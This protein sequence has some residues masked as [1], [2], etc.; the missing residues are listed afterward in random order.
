MP[1]LK[2]QLSKS[3]NSDTVKICSLCTSEE[4]VFTTLL[5]EKLINIY[6][7]FQPDMPVSFF[8]LV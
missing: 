6:Q 1:R 4:G 3:K 7:L 8:Y 2:A 5:P